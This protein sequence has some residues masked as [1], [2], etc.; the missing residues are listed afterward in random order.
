L[1]QKL[2][3][4][5]FNVFGPQLPKLSK[6]F[7]LALILKSWLRHAAGSASPSYGQP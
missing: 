7:K 6:P 2:E 5:R 3:R 4:E 1:L